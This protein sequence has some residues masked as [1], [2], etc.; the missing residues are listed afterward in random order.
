[1]KV[2]GQLLGRFIQEKTG[3]LS[4]FFVTEGLIAL[5]LVLEGINLALFWVAFFTPFLV[6]LVF[7]ILAYVKFVR[8]HQFLTKIYLNFFL[9]I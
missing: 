8:L 5:I 6:F 4:A 9:L 1:M 2:H 7:Q 3:E